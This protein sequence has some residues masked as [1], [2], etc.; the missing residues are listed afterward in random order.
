M[1]EKVLNWMAVSNRIKD[2]SVAVLAGAEG[3]SFFESLLVIEERVQ[4]FQ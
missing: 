4:T 2:K 3:Q 1:Y